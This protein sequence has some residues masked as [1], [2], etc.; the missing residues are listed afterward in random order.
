MSRIYNAGCRAGMIGKKC[1]MTR[2]IVMDGSSVPVTLIYI[3]GNFVIEHKMAER[4]G[5]D[6]VILGFGPKKKSNTP[7]ALL[8]KFERANVPPCAVLK[9]FRVSPDCFVPIGAELS[10]NH[11]VV[12]QY[13]D[14]SGTSIGRGFSGVMKR[15]NF[16][17]LGAS[18]G[19]SI[20]HR[21]QGSTGACQDPG[22]VMKGKKMAG[23][24][25]GSH[26]TIQN[27]EVLSVD[28]ELGVIAVVGAVP[29]STGSYVFLRD[30]IKLS[31]VA[32]LPV[33]T[34]ASS[35]SDSAVDS[36]A[37]SSAPEAAKAIPAAEAS[38]AAV[39][40][41]SEIGSS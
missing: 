19:V 31:G 8:S 41:A 22:R 14:V 2:V 9:E 24:Y 11:F 23:R 32:D 18:H 21:S 36:T 29:G 17:G 38:H 15:H 1:G 26:C 10:V 13:L 35:K 30:A 33:P 7:K 3:A 27:L 16:A 12:G 40:S 34:V 28:D 20:S 4:D 39:D 5:Y 37:A 25:G 6:S